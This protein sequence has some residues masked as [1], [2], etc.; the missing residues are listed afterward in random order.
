M[1]SIN[2]ESKVPAQP[3]A[4]AAWAAVTKAALRALYKAL[5]KALYSGNEAPELNPVQQ[6]QQHVACLH[7]AEEQLHACT[8]NQLRHHMMY[9]HRQQPHCL[10]LLCARHR[11][12]MQ[13]I[14]QPKH[15]NGIC[16][17]ACGRH[18][19]RFKSP[20]CTALLRKQHF[21]DPLDNP[22]S[23]SNTSVTNTCCENS[24]ATHLG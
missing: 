5:Y 20:W 19:L 6:H 15:S 9:R 10:L 2:E 23:P 22:P 1:H 4:A 3:V 18:Q 16:C 7:K 11:Q 14:L 8:H 24:T 17:T 21:C 13:V 12:A